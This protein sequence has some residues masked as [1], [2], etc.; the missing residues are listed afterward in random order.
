MRN[1]TL[2]LSLTVEDAEVICG[3]LRTLASSYIL[4]GEDDKAYHLIHEIK[5][6][7]EEIKEAYEHERS[8]VQN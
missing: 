4:N 5:E 7:E 6:I 1:V 2:F 3:K 8:E